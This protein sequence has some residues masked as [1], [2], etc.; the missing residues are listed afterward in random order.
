MGWFDKRMGTLLSK[1]G[2]GRG[3]EGRGEASLRGW[4]REGRNSLSLSFSA[5]LAALKGVVEAARERIH[6]HHHHC[7]V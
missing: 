2:E 7:G 3:G 6:H 4:R 5:Y 1:F